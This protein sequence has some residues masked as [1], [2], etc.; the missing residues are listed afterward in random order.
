MPSDFA[1]FALKRAHS[2]RRELRFLAAL[3]VLPPKVAAFQWRARRLASR[4]G[5]DFSRVSA[6][7]PMKLATL[8][9]LAENRRC[10]VELGTATGWTSISLLLADPRRV[11]VSYDVIHRPE[12]DRYLQLVSAAVRRRL[13]F[14]CAAGDEGPRG[15]MQVELLYIDS[16]H[17]RT[18]TIREVQAWK[19]VLVAGALIVF[20]D[21]T[22]DEYPGVREAVQDL[23]LDGQQRHGLFV[24]HVGA[25]PQSSDVG[26]VTRADGSVHVT[27]AL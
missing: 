21:Y 4:S 6:T 25:P 8:L 3:R 9:S 17:A 12:L 27:E 16:S 26:G 23:G 20:D 5:D 11:L 22:H 13:Q 15:D 24:H 1:T 10:V 7:R 2:V 14:V 19:S 18:P